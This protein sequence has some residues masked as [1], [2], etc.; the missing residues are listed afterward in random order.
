VKTVAV[1]EARM[2]SSR[3]PGKVL[4]PILEQPV[5]TYMVERVKQASAIDLIVIATTLN[6]VDDPIVKLSKQMKV[7]CY[8]GSELDVLGRVY[9]ASMQFDA[10]SILS[11]T[12]D[13]PLVDPWVISTV[14]S[15]YKHNMVD[16]VSNAHL[17]SYPVGMDAEAISIDALKIAH[18]QATDS[19]QR[20]H[21]SLFIR[22]N[23]TLFKTIH[24]YA[25]ERDY[26]PHLG[27]TLDEYD[28]LQL[29]S[30]VARHFYPRMDYTCSEII[31]FVEKSGL[32]SINRHIVRKGDT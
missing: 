30:I 24:L 15:L 5:L 29:I 31:S 9:E 10:T 2:N 21:T 8:R 16:L 13:C 23:P 3:F 12:G 6:D 26:K 18:S 32:D 11:L 20:E 7:E 1:I 28:D 25:H 14:L 27:L 17:R 4:K 22:Q 19:L